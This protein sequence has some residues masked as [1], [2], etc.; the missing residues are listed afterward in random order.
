MKR[1]M[2]LLVGLGMLLMAGSM[3][4]CFG[5]GDGGGGGGLGDERKIAGNFQS[6]EGKVVIFT[7]AGTYRLF[8]NVEEFRAAKAPDSE[9]AYT[10]VQQE[11][12]FKTDEGQDVPERGILAAGDA[13]FTWQKFPGEVFTRQSENPNPTP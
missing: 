8:L 1:T 9:A 11:I 6:N 5:I 10:I 13:S 12:I 7:Q 2:R 3:V 4:G